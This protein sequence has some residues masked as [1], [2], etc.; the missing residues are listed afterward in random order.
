MTY[1]DSEQIASVGRHPCRHTRGRRL[2][3][4]GVGFIYLAGCV[5]LGCRDVGA[6]VEPGEP[7]SIQVVSPSPPVQLAVGETVALQASV[8]DYS[9]KVLIDATVQWFSS[10]PTIVEIDDLG[11]ATGRAVGSAQLWASS[12]TVQSSK[13][14]VTVVDTVGGVATVVTTPAG[15]IFV[16]L[17]ETIQFQ[18]E[19]RDA[20]G[21]IVGSA[22]IQWSSSNS[23]TVSIDASGL[24]TGISTGTA[25]IRAESDGVQSTPVVVTVTSAAIDFDTRIQPIFTTS[26][27]FSGCHGGANPKEG[28]SLEPGQAYDEIVNVP[29]TRLPEWLL[30]KPGDPDASL[31]YVK[32]ATDNP[33]IGSRMPLGGALSG[34]D[35]QAIRNWIAVGAP[36]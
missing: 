7:A 19:A 25:E 10:D 36:R 27:G 33:P 34:P 22:A 30:V 8:W 9:G 15:S 17:G 28:L 6:P 12:E 23:A 18:A 26:C 20:Q 13:L 2:A 16:S 11:L 4:L 21:T 29:S 5:M 31:L 24:A 3:A 35:I 32:I 1:R 14:S